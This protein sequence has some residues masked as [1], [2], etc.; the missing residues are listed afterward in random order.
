MQPATYSIQQLLV[1]EVYSIVAPTV[2]L[3]SCSIH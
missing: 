2:N 1:T 3:Q